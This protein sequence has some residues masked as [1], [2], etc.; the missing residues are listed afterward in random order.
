MNVLT[1]GP[2]A[3]A[4]S[5][6]VRARC[7]RSLARIVHNHTPSAALR[8][9]VPLRWGTWRRRQVTTYAAKDAPQ[10]KEAPKEAAKG[11]EAPKFTKSGRV[12]VRQ[13][14]RYMQLL[15]AI[16]AGEV[17]EMVFAQQGIDRSIAIFKDG[18]VKLCQLPTDDIAV[19]DM[20]SVH[21]VKATLAPLEPD[22]PLVGFRKITA[23]FAAYWLPAGLILAVYAAVMYKSRMKGDWEDRK[24]LRELEREKRAE[25]KAEQ[26]AEAGRAAWAD[27]QG[28]EGDGED[29]P[30]NEFDEAKQFMT[31]NARVRVPGSAG[32]S[33]K[34]GKTDQRV[35]FA[36][37][38]GI[39]EAKVELLEVVDFFRKP[40]KYRASGSRIPRGIL[41]AGPP[42]CGKTLLARAVAGESGVAFFS[43]TASEF[44]E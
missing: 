30:A 22:P 25:Q 8:P 19:A 27:E 16:R 14:I 41:L 37:V 44:V 1:Q 20:M 38:A 18:S 12:L 34:D 3:I 24:K 32:A 23:D 2:T 39:G 42:G 28:G 15:D 6:T 29:G 13:E 7:D 40:E 5:S 4:A 43:M 10:S 11:K 35:T 21:G 36:D 17:K 31:V 9:C 33:D 26:K